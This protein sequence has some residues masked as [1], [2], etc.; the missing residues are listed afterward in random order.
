MIVRI[1]RDGEHDPVHLLFIK[2]WLQKK[3]L[4][5]LRHLILR[6]KQ[7]DQIDESSG[8]L[9]KTTGMQLQ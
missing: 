9:I 3:A 2:G 5:F 1:Y 6:P 4:T 8:Q 7:K